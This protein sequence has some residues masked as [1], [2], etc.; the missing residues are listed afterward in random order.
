MLVV[1]VWYQC[2]SSDGSKLGVR[3]AYEFRWCRLNRDDHLRGQYCFPH[4]LEQNAEA[5]EKPMEVAADEV[6]K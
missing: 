3:R 2:E 5:K 1:Q 4:K 6:L